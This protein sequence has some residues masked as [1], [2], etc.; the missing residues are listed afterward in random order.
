MIGWN[1][2]KLILYET[3]NRNEDE[4]KDLYNTDFIYC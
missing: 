1:Y 2:K 3:E 4:S